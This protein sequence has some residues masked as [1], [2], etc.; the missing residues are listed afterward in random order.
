MNF[1]QSLTAKTAMPAKEKKSLTAKA[2]EDAKET[3]FKPIPEENAKTSPSLEWIHPRRR[4]TLV[5]LVV[6]HPGVT[7]A[8]L[9]AVLADLGLNLLCFL[10]VLGGKAFQRLPSRP[11]RSSR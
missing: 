6:Y 9:G 11:P 10:C 7:I 5:N 2:A 1:L 3:I 8:S 4:W